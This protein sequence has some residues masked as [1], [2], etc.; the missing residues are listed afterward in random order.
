[1]D[2]NIMLLTDCNQCT[3]NPIQV[4]QTR[5]IPL[6]NVTDRPSVLATQQTRH[7]V[8][9]KQVTVAQQTTYIEIID[10]APWSDPA[11]WN[12]CKGSSILL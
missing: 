9:E 6:L 2:G 1:M 4:K 3:D 8:P 7:V 10:P 12:I 11:Y 5:V